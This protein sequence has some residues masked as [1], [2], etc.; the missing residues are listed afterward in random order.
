M[1]HDRW[2][3]DP[4]H[5]QTLPQGTSLAR[6][7]RVY[8]ANLTIAAKRQ[9]VRGHVDLSRW[10]EDLANHAGMWISL[11]VRAGQT[12][13]ARELIESIKAVGRKKSLTPSVSPNGGIEFGWDLYRPEVSEWIRRASFDFAKSTLA[14]AATEANKAIQAFRESLRKG[15]ER[16]D[17]TEDLNR[18]IVK[19]F[20][21]PYRAAR[22]AQTEASRAVHQGQ[23]EADMLSGIVSGGEWLA[24]SDACPK[25]LALNGKRVRF[26]EPF[27]IDPK[28]GPY[29]MV[30]QPPLHPH[31]FCTYKSIIDM[32]QVTQRGISNL[33]L[34]AYGRINPRRDSTPSGIGV[35]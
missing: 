13:K 9:A 26:G 25:C 27:V 10:T 15:L 5:G 12:R 30:Y 22:V 8:L 32:S 14:T 11:Y 6:F 23:R 24:S 17:A 1:L 2:I 18:A 4:S 20:D 19:I 7:L 21:D 28:P 3:R 35:R 16:G 31:C 34:L 33:S 29:Q